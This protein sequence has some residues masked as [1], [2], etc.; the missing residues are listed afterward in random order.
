MTATIQADVARSL[1]NLTEQELGLLNVVIKRLCEGRKEKATGKLTFEVELHEGGIT[2][3]W[4][5]PRYLEK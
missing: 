3:K 4:F 2:K 5:N 1:A